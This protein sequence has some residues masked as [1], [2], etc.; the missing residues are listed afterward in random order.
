MDNAV[1]GNYWVV[2]ID[3]RLSGWGQAKGGKSA[4]I[5]HCHDDNQAHECEKAL[6]YDNEMKYV[7][8]CYGRKPVVNNAAHIQELD[9]LKCPRWN[10]DYMFTHNNQADN[11]VVS[12]YENRLREIV[13]ECVKNVLNEGMLGAAMRNAYNSGR[14]DDDKGGSITNGLGDYIKGDKDADRD[15]Y[16]T[17]KGWYK[18]AK[19]YYKQNPVSNPNGKN[20]VG[21]FSNWTNKAV[22]QYD[23]GYN[24][25]QAMY[26][27]PGVGGKLARA[28]TVPAM[29]GANLAGRIARS[30]GG[31][32]LEESQIYEEVKKVLEDYDPN[33]DEYDFDVAADTNSDYFKTFKEAYDYAKSLA[34][35]E[36]NWYEP[37]DVMDNREWKTIVRFDSEGEHYLCSDYYA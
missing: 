11:D 6:S 7:K 23:M 15:S 14:Y 5:I 19:N 16:K 31:R 1:A 13:A 4:V 18:D 30:L 10:K 8:T 2:A 35:K 28:A 27:M 3:K 32:K 36:V 26:N 17:L 33:I 29:V 20:G 9:F 12:I 25:S 21:G 22:A 24:G 37:I 34:M